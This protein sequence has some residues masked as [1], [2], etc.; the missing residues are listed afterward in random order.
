M[1]TVPYRWATIDSL[2]RPADTA[3]LHADYP[4]RGFRPQ[5][6]GPPSE[7][8]YSFSIYPLARDGVPLPGTEQLSTIWQALISD[9]LQPAYR[10]AMQSVIGEPLEHD[11]LTIAAYRFDVG[12]YVA[13]HIDKPSKIAT[14]IIYFNQ[15]W[16]DEWGGF[17]EVLDSNRNVLHQLPP[18]S[19][20]SALLIRSASAWHAVSKVSPAA[21]PRMTV[22]VE[23]WRDCES[24]ERA[25]LRQ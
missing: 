16:S 15:M 2:M 11:S 6:G 12:D 20:V 7:K 14:H 25:H 24:R 23:F 5:R 9:L 22:Q 8:D 4:I 18:V 3:M 1:L 13:P 10:E 19:A 17:L 21:S